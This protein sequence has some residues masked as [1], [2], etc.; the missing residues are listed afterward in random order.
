MLRMN[1]G[2]AMFDLVVNSTVSPRSRLAYTRAARAFV[3]WHKGQPLTRHLVQEYRSH[4]IDSGAASSTINLHLSVLRNLAREAVSANMIDPATAADI[5]SVKGVSQ[6][7]RRDGVWLSSE[8]AQS[9]L[10]RIDLSTPVGRR[11][12]AI[13]GLLIGCALRRAEACCVVIEQ[14]R[15]VE[16]RWAVVDLRGKGGRVRTV[17]IPAWAADAILKWTASAGIV[18]GRV[19]RPVSRTGTVLDRPMT[20]SGLWDVVRRVAKVAP[21]DLRRTFAKLARAGGASLEQIQLTLGHASIETTQ[22]YLG[23]K[24]NFQNAACDRL[25]LRLGGEV[26]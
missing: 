9:I 7:G 1:K 23:S 6:Q 22:R 24:I 17:P 5:V 2:F 16:G 15:Q 20:S 13:M 8:Q 18:S 14:I 3:A 12:A 11:D 21:H 4:L 10:T 26:A 25:G 19:L